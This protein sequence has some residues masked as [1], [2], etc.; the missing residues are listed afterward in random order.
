M[1]LHKKERNEEQILDREIEY[2]DEAKKGFVVNTLK[3]MSTIA[4]SAGVGTYLYLF[5]YSCY[6]LN[7]LI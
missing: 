1:G 3:V 4:D 5:H 2:G 6:I 7:S